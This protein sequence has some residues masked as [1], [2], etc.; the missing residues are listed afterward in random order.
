MVSVV[1]DWL[2]SWAGSVSMYGGGQSECVG[3]VSVLQG[4]LD[5]IG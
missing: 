2:N 1:E 4:G 3:L 5:R